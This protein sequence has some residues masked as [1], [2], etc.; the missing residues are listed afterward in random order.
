MASRAMG[1]EGVLR[2]YHML[3]GVVLG[4]G[5]V[6]NGLLLSLLSV[7][8]AGA[9]ETWQ[10]QPSEAM[11]L[12]FFSALGQGAGALLF[13]NLADR[14]G[15]RRLYALALT[16]MGVST[17]LASLASSLGALVALPLAAMLRE[18]WMYARENVVLEPW[19]VA[20]TVTTGPLVEA[21]LVELHDRDHDPDR[22]EDH[23]QRLHDEPEP[24]ETHTRS[25]S[26]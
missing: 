1:A 24:R 12:P 26:D 17:A 5:M 25:V 16:I 8:L 4:L 9:R 23:D 21:G 19:P 3:V 10:L 18:L 6:S 14:F 11:L 7:A 20:D 22:D 2:P 13:G 15:R